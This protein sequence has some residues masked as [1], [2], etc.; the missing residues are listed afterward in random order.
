MTVSSNS[1]T[2]TFWQK[3]AKSVE[4]WGF[5]HWTYIAVAVAGIAVGYFA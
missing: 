3:T 2:P 1:E 4:T 5:A